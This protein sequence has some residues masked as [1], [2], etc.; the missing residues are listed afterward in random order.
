MVIAAHDRQ[1]YVEPVK[2][3]SLWAKFRYSEEC[4]LLP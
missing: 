3:D 1:Q 2:E 4:F